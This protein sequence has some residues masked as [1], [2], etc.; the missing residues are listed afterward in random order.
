VKSISLL[1]A[2]MAL[3][4]PAADAQTASV[5]Q[6]VSP[7][8]AAP[9]DVPFRGTIRLQVDATDTVRHIFRVHE[10]IPVSG[11]GPMML[12][13]PRWIPGNHAPTGRIDQVAGLSIRAAD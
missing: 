9:K 10:T 13:Y 8:I 6:P 5:M 1:I 2:L 12:L 3:A 11:A 7:E 4:S